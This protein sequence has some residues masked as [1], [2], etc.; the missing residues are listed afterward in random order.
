MDF[1]EAVASKAGERRKRRKTPK[2]KGEE[3]E[4]EE[5]RDT[6]GKETAFGERQ[7]WGAS[8]WKCKYLQEKKYRL[9]NCPRNMPKRLIIVMLVST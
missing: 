8:L 5:Q 4:R 2:E 6:I 3:K 7:G 9:E 1:L